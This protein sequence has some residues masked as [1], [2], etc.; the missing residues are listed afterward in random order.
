MEELLFTEGLDNR[1]YPNKQLALHYFISDGLLF[2]GALE[3]R[4]ITIG[5]I[6]YCVFRNYARFIYWGF[7]RLLYKMGLIIIGEGEAFNW[8]HNFK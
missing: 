4:P 2:C 7:L 3:V 8:R 6:I 5:H 1:I